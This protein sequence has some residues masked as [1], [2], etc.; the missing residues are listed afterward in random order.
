[1]KRTPRIPRTSRIGQGHPPPPSVLLAAI[2]AAAFAGCVGGTDGARLVDGA[3]EVRVGEVASAREAVPAG[4]SVSAREAASAGEPASVGGY[5]AGS[6]HAAGAEHGHGERL[7]VASDY[8]IYHLDTPWTDQH[9]K[10]RPLVSLAGRVQVV[11]MVYTTCAHACPRILADMKRIEASLTDEAL[12]RVGFV[13][14]TIDPERD[15]PEQ[16]A[17]FANAVRLDPERWTLFTAPDN[18][19][20]ELAALLGVQYRRISETDFS[21]TNVITVL[22][23]E[24]EIAHRQEGLGADPEATLQAIDRLL[25]R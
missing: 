16:L 19:I 23:Q 20:L 4:E 5:A 2:A 10:E 13:L 21:H 9:G 22:D 11:A 3:D 8:S 7:V 15:T 17:N 24:G 25:A 18:T 6:S 14:V 1:M 12:D